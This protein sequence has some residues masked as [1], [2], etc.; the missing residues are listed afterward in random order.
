MKDKEGYLKG[1]GRDRQR[2][3][4]NTEEPKVVVVTEEE[5]L[6]TKQAD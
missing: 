5:R 1:V 4:V 2:V 3:K 6:G